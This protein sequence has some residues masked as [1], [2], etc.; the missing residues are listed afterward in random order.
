M[1]LTTGCI[2]SKSM[3]ITDPSTIRAIASAS[4]AVFKRVLEYGKQA[5]Q[6]RAEHLIRLRRDFHDQKRLHFISFIDELALWAKSGLASKE[7]AQYLFGG[8][9]IKSVEGRAMWAEVVRP[10]R[11]DDG[12][13]INQ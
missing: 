5:A 11:G 10:E 1:N 8:F 3:T 12:E 9:V 2:H 13:I 4:F 6:R 7:F